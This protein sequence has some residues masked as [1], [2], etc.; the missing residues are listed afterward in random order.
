MLACD[1]VIDVKGQGI[2]GNRQT[3]IL[4]SFLRALTNLPDNIPVHE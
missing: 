3:A 1:D 4:A 2:D